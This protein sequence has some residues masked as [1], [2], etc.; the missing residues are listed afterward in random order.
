M[1]CKRERPGTTGRGGDRE[2][3]TGCWKE[4]RQPERKMKLRCRKKHSSEVFSKRVITE[5]KHTWIPSKEKK[6]KQS[7]ENSRQQKH[8]EANSGPSQRQKLT[9]ASALYRFSGILKPAAMYLIRQMSTLSPRVAHLS[10]W[11]LSSSGVCGSQ[12]WLRSK[13]PCYIFVPSVPSVPVCS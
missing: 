7:K 6:S 8:P 13:L 1:S 9:M 10:P 12:S 4:Q 2:H 3:T 11:F 5:M